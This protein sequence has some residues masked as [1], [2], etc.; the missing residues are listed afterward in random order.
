[1]VKCTSEV[2]IVEAAW[3]SGLLVR[4]EGTGTVAH[5]GV[6]LPRLLADIEEFAKEDALFWKPSPLLVKLVQEGRNFD[7]LNQLA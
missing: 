3:S 6:V 5:A 1:M 2:K 7:S 4:A